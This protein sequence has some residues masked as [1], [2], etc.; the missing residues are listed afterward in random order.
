M[1]QNLGSSS[2]ARHLVFLGHLWLLLPFLVLWLRIPAVRT[3]VT[4]TQVH[5]EVLLAAFGF[6]YLLI[7]TIVAYKDPPGLKWEYVFPPIDLTFVSLIIYLGS[8]DP[9]SN[10][11]LL[12]FFPIA[13]AAGTLNVGWAATVGILS[14][15]G[16]G[17]ATRFNSPEIFGVVFRF[18]FLVT[19]ASLMTWLARIAA[20]LRAQLSLAADRNRLAMDMHDGV[21]GHLISIASQLELAQRVAPFDGNR[22]AA[23]AADSREVARQAADELRFLVQRL[24]APALSHGFVPALK[25]YGHNLCTRNGAE[26]V[27]E[28]EGHSPAL[29]PEL[30]NGLFRI[31]QEAIQ[32]A[33]K[34]AC[35]TNIRVTIRF[36]NGS[37][38]LRV[39]DDGCGF[40]VASASDCAGIEGMTYRAAELGGSLSVASG[41]SQGTVIE[42]FA[43]LRAPS[44]KHER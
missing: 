36:L 44:K 23:I 11:S 20:E 12:Y 26:F 43:P 5:N 9:L 39:A 4:P 7:R 31:A 17:F 14:V 6:T 41:P 30:E 33:I 37:L 22:A 19:M 2:R 25:Q 18:F 29:R 13:E 1:R 32:N 40:D 16:A 24:R 34:H 27:F 35:A 8:Q 10:V 28:Q 3:L 15:V 21:Q 42:V 38:E